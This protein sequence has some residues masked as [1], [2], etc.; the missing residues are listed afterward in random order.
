[1]RVRRPQ[2]GGGDVARSVEEGK[3]FTVCQPGTPGSNRYG[4][5]SD[6][7]PEGRL[8]PKCGFGNLLPVG[9]L[10]Q[11][12]PTLFTQRPGFPGPIWTHGESLGQTGCFCHLFTLD[13]WP[14][15]DPFSPNFF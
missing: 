12:Q 8:L 3:V 7:R 15:L 2:A 6:T 11:W 5:T 14:Q 13:T 1:Y 9:R 10:A 4:H